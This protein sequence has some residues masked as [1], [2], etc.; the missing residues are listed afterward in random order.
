MAPRYEITSSLNKSTL[1]QN[2]VSLQELAIVGGRY[3][4]SD[5]AGAVIASTTLKAFGIVTEEYRRYVL[6]RS[7]EEAET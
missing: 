5:R 6:D 3:K 1:Q 2:R 7:Y 4:G